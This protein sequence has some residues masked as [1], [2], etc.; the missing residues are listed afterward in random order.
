M[1]L[2]YFSSDKIHECMFH[3]HY[4]LS[5]NASKTVAYE[6]DRPL[7]I[8]SNCEHGSRPSVTDN[9]LDLLRCGS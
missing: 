8:L 6:D 4:L 5:N 7:V 1:A 3:Q 9:V 2:S